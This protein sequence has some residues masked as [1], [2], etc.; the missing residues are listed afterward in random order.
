MAD[1][2]VD[3][4]LHPSEVKGDAGIA[5]MR[6]LLMTFIKHYGHALQFNVMDVNVLRKAQDE[7][8]QYR[9]LQV[10][11]CGWNVLWNSIPRREQDAYIR[12]AER[13]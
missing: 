4:M 10:R 2:P 11:I 7:P 8:E 3:V 9:D 5:A 6:S 12:Q 13:L 1:L